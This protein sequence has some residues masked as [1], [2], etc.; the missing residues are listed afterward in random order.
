MQTARACRSGFSV[1]SSLNVGGN[2]LKLLHRWRL[3]GTLEN[4]EFGFALQLFSL[5]RRYP[6]VQWLYFLFLLQ[7]TVGRLY[8]L[9]LVQLVF[10]W[11]GSLFL[12]KLATSQVLFI[13]DL[14]LV[15]PVCLRDW[16]CSSVFAC[17]GFF[18]RLRLDWRS[19]QR[20]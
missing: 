6:A 14:F 12:V 11:L 17:V 7:L 3:P 4:P 10:E 1:N 9:F 18:R 8:F 19:T 20:T 2:L 13:P 15:D 16:P 5:L